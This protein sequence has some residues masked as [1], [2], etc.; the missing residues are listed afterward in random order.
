MLVI[1]SV[2]VDE[3][4]WCFSNL[5]R[6]PGDGSAVNISGGKKLISQMKTIK[7]H[8]QWR[9]LVIMEMGVFS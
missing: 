9:R 8:A 2:V 3:L 7:A 6:F 1:P 5:F 4:V